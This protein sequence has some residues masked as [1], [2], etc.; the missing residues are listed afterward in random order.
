ME[1]P[2]GVKKK[3]MKNRTIPSVAEAASAAA[4]AAD[5][6]IQMS[7]AAVRSPLVSI[8]RD[9]FPACLSSDASVAAAV[10]VVQRYAAWGMDASRSRNHSESEEE[11]ADPTARACSST[12]SRKGCCCWCSLSPR[13]LPP[14]DILA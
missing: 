3:K 12:L 10:N 5:G 6:S 13:H 7:V 2:E 11:R 9:C 8:H 4:H 14:W 1:A